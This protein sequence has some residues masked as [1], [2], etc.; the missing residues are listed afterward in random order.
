MLNKKI[1]QFLNQNIRMFVLLTALMIAVISYYNLLIGGIS[2]IIF[3]SVVIKVYDNISEQ[4][5]EL[6]R[7]IE[8]AAVQ[9]DVM[10][11]KSLENLP[12][13]VVIADKSRIIW[14]NSYYNE[15]FKGYSDIDK[16]V[17]N[18]ITQGLN[19][20][21]VDNTLDVG[22]KKYCMIK[23]VDK[24]NDDDIFIVYFFDATEE[25]HLK[26][27]YEDILPVIGLIQVDNYDEVMQGLDDLD[28][29]LIVAEVDNRLNKWAN[30]IDACLRK[31]ENDS[32]IVFMTNQKLKQAEEKRFD[33]L[34]EIRSIDVGNKIPITLSM[35]IASYSDNIRNIYMDS[36]TALDLAL[37]RGGDQAV[38]KRKNRI[39]YYGGKTQA[40]EK[41][42]KVKA[43]V[44][45]HALGQL[46]SESSNVIIVSHNYMDMDGLGSAMG[47]LRA[48]KE[49]GKNAYIV[50]DTVNAT[51]QD[52][53]DRVM[54]DEEY[55]SSF[56]D[57]DQVDSLMDERSL[58]VVVD[59][60]RPAYMTYPEI[61]KKVNRI[62]V[63]DHHRKTNDSIDKTILTYME[64]Y[65][66]STSELVTELLQ[67]M[68]DRIE[69]DKIE[70][71]ALM[72]GI[73]LDTKNFTYKTGVRTFE[74]ASFLRRMGADST[75][76]V[77]VFKDDIQ[78]YSIRAEIVKAAEFMDNGIAI[79]IC[80]SNVSNIHLLVAEAANEL[81]N[82]KG[83]EAAFVMSQ[84][85][86]TVI[87]S[88][89][90]MGDVNVQLIL[91]KLG[92]G[93]HLGIAGAQ[94]FDVNIDEAKKLLYEAI[95]KYFEEEMS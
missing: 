78:T 7:E 20:K 94:L 60:Q 83:V 16:K 46:I 95:D 69:L 75:H 30:S 43:R 36:D 5:E 65:A 86:N 87:I 32:Y 42:T 62:V 27:A 2:F 84:I 63:I 49:Y 79:S 67:Y 93:G 35:G 90:S 80:P 48:S 31:Y 91:E 76:V 64:P 88:G 53:L 54:E 72:A 18:F 40:V 85:N 23:K 17:I 24:V 59:T 3:L 9:L 38:V 4:R 92:G 37:G 45:A 68:K 56:I 81:L 1:V 57:V 8:E 55:S 21:N 70:A 82:I 77:Q 52:F 25:F 74:A 19:K 61:L 6:W 89:R 44:I 29:A 47:I 26:K 41:R 73:M 12:L 11:K 28:R 22:D 58:L 10:V 66:S 51:V 13:A 71:E 50:M 34:D 14:R 15:N 39:S 33:I